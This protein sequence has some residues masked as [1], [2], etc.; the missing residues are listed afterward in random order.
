M[1]LIFATNNKNKAL[2]I[3][4]L[5]PQSFTVVTLQEAGIN[6][7]IP[8]P[9]ET[10]EENAVEKARVIYRIT[11]QNCFSED[12]GLNVDGLNGAPGV[13]SARYAGEKKDFKENILKLLS[14][15]KHQE[16]RSAQFRT[17][18]C[19]NIGGTEHLFEGICKGNITIIPRGTG[20]FGYD[21]VFIPE[22]ETKAFAEMTLSEKNF[23]SHRRKAVENMVAFLNNCAKTLI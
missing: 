15:L 7:D 22:N 4:S 11:K 23:Y 10:L 21:S 12:T 16:N 20:G 1:N 5:L 18:I 3:N 13:R 14:E 8:E 6:I 9:H 17:V 2:E 19:L